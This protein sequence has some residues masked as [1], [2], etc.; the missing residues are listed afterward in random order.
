MLALAQ[1]EVKWDLIP[2]KLEVNQTEP[3]SL[4]TISNKDMFPDV[5]WTVSGGAISESRVVGEV[6]FTAP[7]TE[8]IVTLEAKVKLGDEVVSKKE[9]INVLKEGALKTTADILIEVDTASLV[10]V[11]VDEEHPQESFT[12]PLMVKGTFRY[13]PESGLAFAGGSWPSYEMFDDGT[14]GDKVADDGI[15]SINMEFEKSDASV[16]IAFDDASEYRIEFESGITWKMKMAFIDLDEYPDDHSNVK[17]VPDGDKT[18]KWT[19]EMA[20]QGGLYEKN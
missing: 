20:V 10:G 15:W 16:Y 7:A 12:P 17:F 4:R 3:I 18:I 11:Y 8:G 9:E 5:T 13:D 1:T 19:K 2:E 6:D 14:H